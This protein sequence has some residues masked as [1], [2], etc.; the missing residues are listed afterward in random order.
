MKKIFLSTIVLFFLVS[1]DQSTISYKEISHRTD[2][3]KEVIKKYGKLLKTQLKKAI[4]SGGAIEGINICNVMA[5]SISAQLSKET[6]WKISRTSLKPRATKPDAWETMIM[7]SFEQ[8]YAD[9][10]KFKSLFA[11]D[12]VTVDGRPAFRYMQAIKT[13][14]VC[15]SCHGE[16][17][18][19][20]VSQKIKTHYPDDQAT[21]FAQDS[22]RGAFSIVQFLDDE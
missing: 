19:A 15:L 11:Q 16:V 3:S 5:P 10:D 1:C 22:I 20:E 8:K 21:G 18:S 7:Q 12:I 13:E 2:Q 14:L 6:G 9:G 4:K 17:I